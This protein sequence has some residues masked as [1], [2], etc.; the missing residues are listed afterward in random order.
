MGAKSVLVLFV[1]KYVMDK[2]L[3]L[4]IPTYNMELYLRYCLD[5][6]LVDE[7]MDALEV[8]V[9]NDGSRD[10]SLEIAREYEHKYPQTFKVIDKENGNY[11]SCV[12][13]GLEE[14]TGKYVKVLD[15]DDSF[16]TEHFGRYLSFLKETDADLVLSDF[17]VVD[18][19]RAIRK[20][21]KY[22]Q[23]LGRMFEM[24]QVCCSAK[25]QNMQMHA[26]AYRLENLKKLGY[27]QTEGISY[28]DQQWIFL[29]MITV[30]TI[31]YFDEYVYKYLVGRA[32][33]TME[34]VFK[35]QNLL[36][37]MRC[38]LDMASAYESHKRQI[39]DKPILSYMHAR[40]IPFLKAAY[41]TSITHYNL[42]TKQALLNYDNKLKECCLD[43]YELIGSKNISSF[44]TFR[45]IDY[46]RKHKDANMALICMLS[47]LY[48]FVLDMK[49]SMCKPDDM[50]V[51]VS[52]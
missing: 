36:Y 45:Y 1:N 23:G 27:V 50:A 16:D 52:F 37:V 34:P 48:M 30:K 29:P 14:A 31:A 35:F 41:V 42:D 32:G 12:N 13:R 49:K 6:L 18:T 38:G 44:M 4:I 5:S 28:T 43:M 39:T 24:E 26:V 3:T 25:F 46:W 40:L 47:K 8:L 15:A 20:I 11:G 10:C 7:G 19:N 51:P 21:I 33:Q 9:V 2:I 17:A 22:D